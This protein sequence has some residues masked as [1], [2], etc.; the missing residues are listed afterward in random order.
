[1]RKL[2][3]VTSSVGYDGFE[4]SILLLANS[5]VDVFDINILCLYSPPLV[6]PLTLNKKIKIDYILKN[7][8]IV[9]EIFK[10][11]KI[12]HKIKSIQ[13]DVV[14]FTD[15][16]FAK[17][18]NNTNCKKVLWDTIPSKNIEYESIFIKNKK[19]FDLIIVPSKYIKEYYQEM[20][21]KHNINI[22]VKIIPNALYSNT[23]LKSDVSNKNII[24]V[25][26]LNKSKRV[27]PFLNI[28][29]E[30]V[31][32]DKEICLTIIGDG[33]E[34]INIDEYIK[35][36][37]LNNNVSLLGYI[38][39]NKM[40][41]ELSQASLFVQTSKESTFGL[42]LLEALKIG[43]PV[44]VYE[45]TLKITDCVKNELNGYIVKDDIEL[46]ER[47]LDILSN[48]ELRSSMSSCA[49]DM[50]NAY[51]ISSIKMEWIKYL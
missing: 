36:N 44:I 20:F 40:L 17:Y 16:M 14:L 47:I 37:N 34:R 25:G 2:C 1:M 15:I 13:S 31:K 41:E 51:L 32:V 29:K 18:L 3:I 50:S 22:D 28:F 7:N 6:L 46:K 30:I 19:A 33:V 27:I 49:L 38:E 48:Y 5:L 23:E 8:N 45:D 10:S 39:Y 42:T 12:K 4:R 21:N 43:L 35:S 11:Y 24:I 26:K 9:N